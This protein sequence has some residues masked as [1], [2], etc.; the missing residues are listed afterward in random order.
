MPSK[1]WSM[2]NMTSMICS[3]LFHLLLGCYTKFQTEPN[4]IN[5][6]IHSFNKTMTFSLID[7]ITIIFLSFKQKQT[8]IKKL[9]FMW[10][11]HLAVA[12]VHANAC[13]HKLGMICLEPFNSILPLQVTNLFT[14]VCART[15]N[16]IPWLNG[17]TTGGWGHSTPIKLLTCLPAA[18]NNCLFPSLFIV[19]HWH[20]TEEAA[21]I[22]LGGHKS[23]NPFFM[24][25]W[26]PVT[27]PNK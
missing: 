10:T 15:T 3:E 12:G 26:W 17:M 24:V 11:L 7:T 22:R 6:W 20:A 9:F 2:Q 16:W 8:L 25:A 1:P 13:H 5:L 14:F 18:Q 27:R 4:I 21:P 19:Y 23:E